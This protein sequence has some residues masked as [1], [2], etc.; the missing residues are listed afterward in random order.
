MRFCR[1]LPTLLACFLLNLGVIP[2]VCARFHTQVPTLRCMGERA[3]LRA[4]V[5]VCVCVCVCMVGGRCR[6]WHAI[7]S[8]S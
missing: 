4:C 1:Q 2:E 7:V 6:A 5:C 3:G 8:H